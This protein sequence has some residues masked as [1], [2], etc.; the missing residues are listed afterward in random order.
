[1]S[2]CST[3]FHFHYMTRE[4]NVDTQRDVPVTSIRLKLISHQLERDER[5]VRVVHC[6]QGDAL[7]CA[8]EVAISDELLDGLA[9][10]L[11]YFL[12]QVVTAIVQTD[13]RPRSSEL[14][15]GQRQREDDVPSR[16]FFSTTA[17]LT[18]ASNILYR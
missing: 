8:V 11:R 16:S 10:V 17:C 6:L 12:F 4:T 9:S 2:T 14:E 3:S 15:S 18:R 7:V 5:D 13:V 1:M